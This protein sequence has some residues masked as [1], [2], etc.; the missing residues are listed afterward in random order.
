MLS[1]GYVVVFSISLRKA[2]LMV[3]SENQIRISDVVDLASFVAA[4][5]VAYV[6][7]FVIV[8]VLVVVVVTLLCFG[9]FTSWLVMLRCIEEEE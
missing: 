8:V 4:L 7:V 5:V 1:S 6:N 2:C 3:I 9:L